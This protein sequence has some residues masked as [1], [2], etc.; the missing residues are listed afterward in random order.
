M[1]QRSI[2][3]VRIMGN[4]T[5]DP[6]LKTTDNG[7]KICKFGVATNRSWKEADGTI[8]T[9]T[10]FHNIVCFDRRAEVANEY[11]KKGSKVYIFGRLQNSKYIKNN[12]TRTMSQIIM[13]DMIMLDKKPTDQPDQEQEIPT[14]DIDV[15]SDEDQEPLAF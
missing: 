3:E 10:D 12:E 11:L 6:E 8:K 13:N 4:L 5:R 14:E 1:A 15:Y 9:Q 7:K 2:N